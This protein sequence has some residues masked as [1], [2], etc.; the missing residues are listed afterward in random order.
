MGDITEL[1]KR[2]KAGDDVAWETLFAELYEPL[3]NLARSRLARGS[4][5][6]LLDTTG[7]VHEFYLRL[8]QAGRVLVNDREHFMAYAATAMRSVVV[9][10]ARRRAAERR[11]GGVERVT[12]TE[13]LPEPGSEQEILQVHDALETLQKVDPRL[14]R[15]VEMRYFAGMTEQEIGKALGVTERTVRRD[16]EKARLLLAVALKP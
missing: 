5:Q 12:L 7:L 6:T 14:V 1:I 13:S 3:H 10:F 4:A 11:G 9:D 15:V 2:A 8:E 16:W